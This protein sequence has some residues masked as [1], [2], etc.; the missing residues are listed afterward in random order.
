[1]NI[2]N[3]LDNIKEKLK[4]KVF[5][6]KLF[7]TVFVIDVVAFLS[8][9]QVNPLQLLNPLKFLIESPLDRSEERR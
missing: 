4:D 1:M 5:L 9:G 8:L 6:L 7:A 2:K 3:I